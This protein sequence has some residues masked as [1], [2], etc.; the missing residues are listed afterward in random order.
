MRRF[1]RVSVAAVIGLILL[2]LYHLNVR[3]TKLSEVS[4]N[5]A[6]ATKTAPSDERDREA[7]RCEREEARVTGISS[8]AK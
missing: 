8:R 5:P 3:G 1:G 4:G 2:F 6:T 7:R